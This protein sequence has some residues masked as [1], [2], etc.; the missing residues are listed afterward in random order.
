MSSPDS[1]PVDLIGFHQLAEELAVR[2]LEEVSEVRT[3]LRNLLCRAAIR[4]FDSQV[5]IE[6]PLTPPR[7]RMVGGAQAVDADLPP[8][9]L[10]QSRLAHIESNGLYGNLRSLVDSF[11]ILLLWLRGSDF[12]REKIIDW[13]EQKKLDGAFFM[14]DK[15]GPAMRRDWQTTWVVDGDHGEL[16]INK[17]WAI[18]A[19]D[20]GF[21]WVAARSANSLG[22]VLVLVDPESAASLKRTPSGAPYLNGSLQLGNLSGKLRLPLSHVIQKGGV[23]G[24]KQFLSIV[25]PRFVT[26]ICYHLIWLQQQK[27]LTLD[28]NHADA[29]QNI[30]DLAKSVIA[31]PLSAGEDAVLL[32]KFAINELL[33]SL[34]CS[35]AVSVGAPLVERDL[36]GLSKME[37]SSYRCLIEV[38]SR[39]RSYVKN[40]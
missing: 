31:D 22:P 32:L 27:L 21:A 39:T 38:I 40:N 18:G 34:V 33:V 5:L 24:V 1:P 23:A 37:G 9:A 6:D 15:G 36:M 20:F 17:I 13:T 30:R 19:M 8:L 7:R 3:P 11:G 10:I 26:A 25:R 16:T 35:N 2:P 29:L 4:T 12:H 28:D 14:T